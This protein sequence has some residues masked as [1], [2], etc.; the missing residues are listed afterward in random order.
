VRQ[1]LLL[2]EGREPVRDDGQDVGLN[3]R[4]DQVG[5]GSIRYNFFA[6]KYLK[7]DFLQFFVHGQEFSFLPRY[8]V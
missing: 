8:V 3:E 2:A 5:L 6:A 7:N 1:D 4:H